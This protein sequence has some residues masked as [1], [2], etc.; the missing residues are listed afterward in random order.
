VVRLFDPAKSEWIEDIL[1]NQR[2]VYKVAFSP[3][4]RRL[5]STAGGR[6]AIEIWDVG[7]RQELLT[8]AG[9]GSTRS[10]GSWSGYGDMILVGPTWQASSAPSWAEIAAAEAKDP[11]SPGY[12]GHDGGQGKAEIKQP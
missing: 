7:T 12:G 10:R 3:D 4:G 9:A 6:E 5:I 2:A 11:P 8:L 1:G